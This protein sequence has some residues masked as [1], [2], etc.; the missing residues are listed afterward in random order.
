MSCSLRN[1]GTMHKKKK[2]KFIYASS[3][4][5]YG[6][7][8]LGYDDKLPCE[9]LSPLN[10]Y[11]YSKQL[12]DLWV[13]RQPQVKTPW[14]GLKFFNV[15]GPNEYHKGSM[16]SVVFHAYNQI[17]K[18]K[19]IRLFKSYRTE[20]PHGMQKRDFIYIKDA[21]QMI[22]FFRIS[23]FTNGLYNIASGAANSFYDLAL[24]TFEAMQIKPRISFI[25]MPVSLRDKY[26]YYTLGRV[27]K[28]Q[29]QGYQKKMFSFHDAVLDYTAEYLNRNY[30]CL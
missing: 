16:A 4:A 14:A 22:D 11:G 1:F 25:D 6:D 23:K 17:V 28:L 8:S 15:F 10:K 18:C 27:N 13:M 26:Q 20:I 7:G 12:F 5:T 24:H 2:S 3:A 21:V 19:K 30:K 9:D 29:E